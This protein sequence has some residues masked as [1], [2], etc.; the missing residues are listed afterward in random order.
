MPVI[1]PE[2]TLAVASSAAAEADDNHFSRPLTPP[3]VLQPYYAE[4]YRKKT[5]CRRRHSI[6]LSPQDW[7]VNLKGFGSRAP[8]QQIDD[9]GHPV[10]KRE[11]TVQ[12][13]KGR[14]VNR[15]T[16]AFQWPRRLRLSSI[17]ML[18]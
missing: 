14:K 15:T 3:P 16:T 4:P 12:K 10:L 6:R 9:D 5:R 7:V 13:E 17:R 18:W 1:S 2:V 8:P 11:I